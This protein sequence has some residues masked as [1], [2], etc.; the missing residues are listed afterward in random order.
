MKKIITTTENRKDVVKA[1]CEIIGEDSRY[2][3]VPSCGYQIGKCIV[4]RNGEVELPDGDEKLEEMILAGLVERGLVEREE[5][6]EE[7]EIKIPMGEHTGLSLKNLVFMIHSKQYLL[8]KAFGTKTFR[9]D[10]G[11]LT[12]L[13]ETDPEGRGEFL[14][15][16][17]SCK[18]NERNKGFYFTEDEIVFEAFPFSENGEDMG[19]YA[20]LASSMCT[21]VLESKRVNPAETIA[22]NEKYYM[23]IWL[24]RL[25][26]GGAEG[27]KIRQVMLA[28]LKGHSAFRTPED[29]ERARVR[30]RQRAEARKQAEQKVLEQEEAERDAL[31]NDSVNQLLSEETGIT[32]EKEET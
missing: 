20:K 18:G 27:K 13:Q 28:N 19:A 31:M 17:H 4:N 29:I 30:G 25:G 12:K 24:L 6:T 14:E 16:L 23:R 21:A 26:L 11:F 8:N 10:E 7:V 9:V 22:E 1:I 3:G 5:E 32:E 2:L 15:L